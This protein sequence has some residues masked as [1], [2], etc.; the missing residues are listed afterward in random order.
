MIPVTIRKKILILGLLISLSALDIQ[1]GF[2]QTVSFNSPISSSLPSGTLF[3]ATGD[4][5]GD[6]KLD[7]ATLQQFFWAMATVP[8]G[9]RKILPLVFFRTL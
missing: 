7:V 5:N 2:T 8:S 6:G 1:F 9:L 4:F 3:V